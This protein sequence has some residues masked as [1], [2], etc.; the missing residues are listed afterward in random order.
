M[1]FVWLRFGWGLRVK[2]VLFDMFDTLYMI[3]KDHAFYSTALRAAYKFLAKNGVSVEFEVF[4]KAYVGARY[5]LYERADANL[6]EPHFNVRIADALRRLGY[7]CGVS[8]ALVV[9]ATNAFCDAFMKYVSIEAN[10]D[11]RLQM[12]HGK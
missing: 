2:A 1:S 9:G 8:D 12:L 5:A 4:E 7:N 6:E 10:A 11:K 3:E